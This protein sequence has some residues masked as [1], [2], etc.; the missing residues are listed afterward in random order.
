MQAIS[1]IYR[2]LTCLF[3]IIGILYEPFNLL[4]NF[5]KMNAASCETDVYKDLCI[6]KERGGVFDRIL[7]KIVTNMTENFFNKKKKL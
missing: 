6:K 1:V 2:R 3:E 7:K 5:I 4:I